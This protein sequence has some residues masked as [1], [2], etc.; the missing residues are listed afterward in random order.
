MIIR[1]EQFHYILITQRDHAYAAGEI[2]THLSKIFIDINQF[3]TVKFVLHQLNRGWVTP[4]AHLIIN[5][6]NKQP[7][8]FHNYPEKFKLHFCKLSIEQ[9]A[10]ANLYAALLI[11]MYYSLIFANNQSEYVSDFVKREVLRQN[12]LINKLK[13]DDIAALSYQLTLIKFCLNISMYLCINKVGCEKIKEA[14]IFKRGFE[15]SELFHKN[16]K[17]KII[18]SY[19]SKESSLVRFNSLILES[20]FDLE[21]PS[22]A[23]SK[24]LISEIGIDEAYQKAPITFISVKLIKEP[25]VWL[26]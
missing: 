19:R 18:A 14:E 26:Q 8:D 24:Q 2:L 25:F 22:K 4:D 13:I 23:V 15:G 7:Y 6:L 16:D 10:Q 11:S 1:Q 3:E 21:I 20:D 5:D 9:V 17:N 12:Y